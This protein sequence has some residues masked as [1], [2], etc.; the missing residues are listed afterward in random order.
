MVKSNQD[1][2]S[3]ALEIKFNS[4]N[5]FKTATLTHLKPRAYATDKLTIVQ[6][7][8][9]L[10][11]S[12]N[13]N[14]NWAWADYPMAYD[15][16]FVATENGAWLD[17]QVIGTIES[18]I[19]IAGTGTGINGTQKDVRDF[20]TGTNNG[21]VT[22]STGA[23][24]INETKSFADFTTSVFGTASSWD[25]W[26]QTV[27]DF[28]KKLP[29]MDT[30]SPISV[31]NNNLKLFLNFIE[32]WWLFKGL[33][34][35][36]AAV[37]LVD[38]LVGGGKKNEQTVQPSF[39]GMNLSLTGSIKT[40]LKLPNPR[41]IQVPS[42]KLNPNI[43]VFGSN[44]PLVYNSNVGV[45]NLTSTP[46]V[47][48]KTYFQ[49]Y[50]NGQSRQ[51]MDCQLQGNL[52]FSVNPSSGLTLDSMMAYI[53][54]DPSKN[55]NLQNPTADPDLN[56]LATWTT[57]SNPKLA[58]ETS[59][60][61]K[62]IFRSRVVPY[63]AFK[64]Q[65]VQGPIGNY[66]PDITIKIKAVLHR[67]DD[68]AAQPVLMVITYE[69]DLVAD[70]TG[71]YPAY[72]YVRVTRD[73]EFDAPQDQPSFVGLVGSQVLMT[74][75]PSINRNGRNYLF[76][77]WSDGNGDNPRTFTI[78]EN[79]TYYSARYRI[80]ATSNDQ[81]AYANNNQRKFVRT[82]NGYYHRV[83]ESMNRVWYER[84]TNNGANWE[85]MKPLSG[86]DSKSPSI[87]AAGDMVLVVFQERNGDL[88]KIILK[89]FIDNF[90]SEPYIIFE[91]YQEPY[92]TDLS[93]VIAYNA[94]NN[95][96]AINTL[97]IWKAPNP[98][99]FHYAFG[100]VEFSSVALIWGRLQDLIQDTGGQYLDN[101]STNLAL[102]CSQSNEYYRYFSFVWEQ[103]TNSGTSKIN[104]C[105]LREGIITGGQNP[106]YLYKT[107]DITTASNGS[108]YTKNSKPSL[109]SFVT[110]TN[111]PTSR[112]CWIGERGDEIPN[113]TEGTEKTVV[114]TDTGTPNRF[115]AF[116]NGVTSTSINKTNDKY[117]IAW[118]S[119]NN[120]LITFADNSTL[121]PVGTINISG[122]D[123]QLSNGTTSNTMYALA[124]NTNALP[125]YMQTGLVNF[126]QQ[127]EIHPIE[128]R[129]GIVS[130]EEAQVYFSV[131]DAT[132]DN[133]Q[134]NFAEIP[135]T[136]SITSQQ[137]ANQ[138]LISEPFSLTDNSEF[139]YSVKYGLTD[140]LAALS[141]LN[142]NKNLTFKVELLDAVTNEVLGVFDEVTY[143]QGNLTPYEKIDYQVLTN[144][145]GER[146][147]KLR[148]VINSNFSPDYSV[149]EKYD[150]ESGLAKKQYKQIN[151]QGS[152]AVESY[153]LSQNYPNP[154]NPT[155]T[156]NYQ[157]KEDGLVT[158]KLYD[159][160]GAEVI[161]LVNEEK[162]KGRYV[163]NFNGSGLAS[164]V[165]IY[166]LRVNDFV[167]AKKLILLK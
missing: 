92:Q 23:P 152:L 93:P 148:L 164:G 44:T 79:K 20:L 73:F 109:V 112:I 82:S 77:G 71:N 8:A 117:A 25:K 26:K 100:H 42:S 89:R 147:V 86:S 131:G 27:I 95:S 99:S 108:A 66:T 2:S 55:V 24:A 60:E 132:V 29:I 69:P 161:T 91:E 135:D 151:Y 30:P 5:T 145:I 144:G 156:I 96:Q 43:A 103:K 98:Y 137:K 159:I 97:V 7:N 119:G 11:L 126:N 40:T 32:N 72:S 105:N 54:M 150:T 157:I 163:Q 85:I 58:L 61:G 28:N 107:G 84:S 90:Q 121:R 134:I 45:L 88:S 57:S 153:D 102:S 118:A 154:F 68:P 59:S 76:S 13:M 12:Q 123:V 116:G 36:G 9:G 165:Y 138:Y 75:P 162:S 141:M 22:L 124:F 142:G 115:W 17:F 167:S 39:T 158:L 49:P 155:T 53:V 110:A 65:R 160:L 48:Y 74:T 80:P 63:D 50:G 51:Y 18:Q 83:Y 64:Y 104:H 111:Q 127:H 130:E 129:E 149:A 87:E 140:S 31:A 21:A 10:A 113:Y 120:N 67:N 133:E 37:G 146:T 6:N 1:L 46:I 15:P 62:F 56:L 78:N 16:T 52:N 81:N 33:P 70:G 166:R 136:V 106:Y 128:E 47:K 101:N 94:T 114:F 38:F 35:I 41:R 3:G 125:Y 34:F 122:K 139:F 4:D 19:N 14:D 143:D